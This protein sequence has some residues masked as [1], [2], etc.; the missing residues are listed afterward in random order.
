MKRKYVKLNEGYNH[1]SLGNVIGVIKGES[2]NKTNAVQS[3][4]FCALFNV[5]DINDSTVNNYCIGSRS[6]NDEYKQKYI[7]LRNRFEK[8]KNVFLAIVKDILTITSGTIYDINE[9]D[10]IN[11]NKDLEYVCKKL[12]NIA[13]NDVYILK[14]YMDNF[15]LLYDKKNYYELLFYFL[16]YAILINKQPLYEDEINRNVIES[17]LD[18]TEISIND[19]KEY[20][21][22]EINGGCNFDYSLINL[23]KSGNAYAN[24]QLGI[25]EYRGYFDGKPNYE[26]AFNYFKL[27]ALKNHPSAYWQMGNMIKNG[28]MGNYEYDIAFNYFNKAR[29]LGNIAAINSLGIMYMKGL[30]VKKD[31]E[32][33][34]KLFNEAADMGYAYAYNNLANYYR[35]IDK[36]KTINYLNKSANMGESYAC[37]ELGKIYLEEKNYVEAFNFFNRAIDSS[38]KE[39][40]LWAYYYLAKY[41][42]LCGN[43]HN[44]IVKDVDKAIDYFKMSD[45]LIDSLC[46]LLFIYYER[47][48]IDMV[49]FYKEKIENH[50]MFNDEYK[51]MIEDI[52]FKIKNKA[53]LDIPIKKPHLL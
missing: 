37:K 8:N 28:I 6:I 33:A 5:N 26:K 53:I 44:N 41:F 11:K 45:V 32:M 9:I 49:W 1:L 51:K 36:E 4:I 12:Y 35:N 50:K 21:V 13:K 40:N 25:S 15:T 39:K 3:H 17:L 43:S 34:L 14:E 10:I 16:V 7:I 19:L 27:A 48:E 38:L 23:A 18:N 22:L 46:E 24:Y 20:L 30:G 31:T 47:N 52:L 2:I 29:K 42:Y